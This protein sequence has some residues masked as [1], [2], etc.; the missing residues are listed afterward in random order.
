MMRLEQ[1]QE[2][3][4]HS[5]GQMSILMRHK[6]KSVDLEKTLVQFNLTHTMEL[7]TLYKYMNIAAR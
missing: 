5:I 6:I 2:Q 4:T 3:N 7:Y 1:E